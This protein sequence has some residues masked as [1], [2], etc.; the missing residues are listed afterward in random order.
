MLKSTTRLRQ[1]LQR[2]G[3]LMAAGAFSPM[4]ARIAEQTG[5]EAIYMPG[6]GT[7]L[8]R[9]GVADLGLVTLTEM[10]DNAGAIAHS[11]GVPVIADADTG[12]G[13]VLNVQRTVQAYE[14]AGVAAIHIEDQEFPKRCGSLP[15]KSLIPLEEAA[16]KI[17]AAVA[18]KEDPDFMIIARCDALSVEGLD[19]TIQRGNAYLQAGADMLFIEAAKTLEE[20]AFIPKALPA[21]HLYNLPTSGKMPY[22]SEDELSKL[23]YKLMLLPNF[24][25]LAAIKA[26]R[27]VLQEIRRTGSVQGVLGQCASFDDFTHLGRLDEFQAWE[28][29]YGKVE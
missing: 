16:E 4:P 12:F 21:L 2:D 8:N 11:V 22:L 17:R 26:M 1:L 3:V 6:G 7:A 28:R 23:G 29:K 27:E 15:G 13:N 9:L 25:T 5:F 14:R 20:I 24:T 19:A 18:A 10:A